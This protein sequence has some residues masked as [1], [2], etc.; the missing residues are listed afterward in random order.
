MSLTPAFV[1][2]FIILI[3]SFCIS[4]VIVMICWKSSQFIAFNKCYSKLN[5]EE[6]RCFTN[7]KACHS[8][9]KESN[10]LAQITQTLHQLPLRRGP[11]VEHVAEMW[12]RVVCTC[13]TRCPVLGIRMTSSSKFSFPGDNFPQLS[14]VT[15]ATGTWNC[16]GVWIQ[17]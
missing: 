15:K 3:I 8:H 17:C 2:V 9:N 13:L 10:E 1:E 16:V 14:K 5:I 11:K 4:R 6:L 7:N 12:V